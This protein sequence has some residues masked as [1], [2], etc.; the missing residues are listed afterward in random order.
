M[1]L[2]IERKFLIDP[3]RLPELGF[4]VMVQQG[5]ISSDPT[6]RVRVQE[7]E[8][9]PVGFVTIKGKGTLARAEYEYE[10]PVDDAREMLKTLCAHRLE[11]VRYEVRYGDHT[12]EVDRFVG[13]HTGLWLAE[14][15]L[16]MAT[17]RFQLP[18][19]VVNEVTDDIS[20]TNVMLAQRAYSFP[21]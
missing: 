14:I 19:W 8:G 10:V 2:E 11:K 21:A 17:E 4:G 6:V 3:T 18:P 16:R 1:G 13:R 7:R 9:G 20:Y 15:E 12:W 5:Y